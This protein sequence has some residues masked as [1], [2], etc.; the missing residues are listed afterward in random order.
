MHKQP[1]GIVVEILDDGDTVAVEWDEKW[2]PW[3]FIYTWGLEPIE[4]I[5]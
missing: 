4:R 2:I 1:E 3:R 5:N